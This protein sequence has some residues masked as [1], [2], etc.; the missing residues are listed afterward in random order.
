MDDLNPHLENIE[1]DD[2]DDE[3][4]SYA[5]DY[6]LLDRSASDDPVWVLC[7]YEAV[8]AADLD[9]NGNPSALDQLSM[10]QWA[11]QKLMK[12]LNPRP[13]SGSNFVFRLEDGDEG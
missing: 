9:D 5:L 7:R 3:P 13:V 10:L 1:I 12:V 8:R 2:L 4:R 11:T 6:V